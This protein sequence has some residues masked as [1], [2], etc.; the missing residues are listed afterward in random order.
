[1][2]Q[3][4]S[5]GFSLVE[6]LIGGAII[7][8]LALG[9]ASFVSTSTSMQKRLEQKNEAFDLRQQLQATLANVATC[10]CQLTDLTF[11]SANSKLPLNLVRPA[12]GVAQALAQAGQLLPGT[13]TGLTVSNVSVANLRPAGA[14]EYL[15]EL[16][17]AFTS[18]S[19]VSALKPVITTLRL[20]V[21][22]ASP[23]SAVKITGCVDPAASELQT[24]LASVG[25][26]EPGEVLTGFDG[27][28]NKICKD[29]GGGTVTRSSGRC[30][31]IK[32]SCR[33][34][35]SMPGYAVCTPTGWKCQGG[36]GG[37][38]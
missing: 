30:S 37:C 9:F 5:S 34:G 6:I 29:A 12:C 2:K 7:S 17:V 1:M 31:G 22:P 36:T 16:T 3:K 15:G 24:A 28:G 23:P 8:I 35:G 20:A 18:G 32:P 21:D 27:D 38:S 26:C 4:K 33:C 14:G 13:S 11:D 25:T 19:M 10:S